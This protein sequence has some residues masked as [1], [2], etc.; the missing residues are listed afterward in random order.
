M[1][2]ATPS[3]RLPNKLCGNCRGFASDRSYCKYKGQE[4]RA[5][6]GEDCFSFLALQR[7]TVSPSI[8]KG[9]YGRGDAWPGCPEGHVLAVPGCESKLCKWIPGTHNLCPLLKRA[10][11]S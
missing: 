8:K 3:S 5:D 11:D 6:W 10:Q 2:R 4:N 9:G 1:A 7:S